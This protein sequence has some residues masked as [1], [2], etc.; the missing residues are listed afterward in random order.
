MAGG[1]LMVVLW[2][3]AGVATLLG[4]VMLIAAVR[5]RRV[6]DHPVCRRCRF[7]LVGLMPAAEACPECGSRLDA[8]N[9]VRVGA[10]V[11]RYGGLRGVVVAAA[12][13]LIG[14]AGMGGLGVTAVRGVNIYVKLPTA[15]L[16]TISRVSDSP[17]MLTELLAR[18]Q[19][20]NVSTSSLKQLG[21][22][23]LSRQAAAA[24]GE[25]TWN[26]A[27]GDLFVL[28]WEADQMS[29]ADT[30]AFLDRAFTP[31]VKHRSRVRRGQP[32]G[33]VVMPT[34][35]IAP[36][37]F[38]IVMFGEIG[39]DRPASG[40]PGTSFMNEWRVGTAGWGMSSTQLYAPLPNA[41]DGERTLEVHGA[42]S[43]HLVP[44]SEDN[45]SLSAALHAEGRKDAPRTS[46]KQTITVRQV[47]PD[48][49]IVDIVADENAV[50]QLRKS[51]KIVVETK[52]A[53]R[54]V[55]SYE[56]TPAA[57]ALE[58]I[59]HELADGVRTGRRWTGSLTA[60]GPNYV[61]SACDV[62]MES[63]FRTDFAAERVDVELVNCT[64]L[65]SLGTAPEQ[66]VGLRAVFRNVPVHSGDPID[67]TF[68][69]ADEMDVSTE[70]HPRSERR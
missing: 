13:L 38:N 22:R 46:W 2:A 36:S 68:V 64:E 56:Q 17:Q 30:R 8:K 12:V 25:I 32:L 63:S 19:A 69:A 61:C 50:S 20:G 44:R 10:R 62:D 47:A 65:V 49:P 3:L 66:V 58:A 39:I 53:P 70:D 43:V 33:L 40:A 51:L 14:L 7:D 55:A 34:S 5:G 15:V 11:R 23:A 57:I 4:L 59:V 35:A 9:A 37:A 27:W 6:N 28:A 52:P 67:W 16:V 48:A 18:A 41:D 24:A 26:T 31:A 21:E 29:E 1:V 42:W 54:V 45:R 60:A